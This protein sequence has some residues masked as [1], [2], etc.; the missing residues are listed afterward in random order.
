MHGGQNSHSV[1]LQLNPCHKTLC[2]LAPAPACVH[3]LQVLLAL[4][5]SCFSWRLA[6]CMD[7]P[8]GVAAQC[9][10]ALELRVQ[11]GMWL[12]PTRRQ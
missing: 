11:Q 4:L 6:P 7:G 2:V 1:Q 10:A 12:V 9:M 3:T 5:V 8:E